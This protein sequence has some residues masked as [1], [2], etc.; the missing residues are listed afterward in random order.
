MSFAYEDECEVWL[1]SI[2]DDHYEEALA[3]VS[4]LLKL[5]T[6]DHN[7][8]HVSDTQEPRKTRYRGRQVA[9]YRLVYCV[10]N[11]AV[12]S[13]D[14][15]VRHRCHNRLCM[16]PDHLTEGTRADNKRDDWANGTD[17]RLL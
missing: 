7:G 4:S 17:H 1:Q 13:E 6:V 9:A 12:V 15:V 2:M 11:R 10:L 8:C 16:N 3:R 5:T 14:V